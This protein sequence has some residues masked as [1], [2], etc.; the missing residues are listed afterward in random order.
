M[1]KQLNLLH[2]QD[3]FV[4]LKLNFHFHKNWPRAFDT[5]VSIDILTHKLV[6][7]YCLYGNYHTVVNKGRL[8]FSLEFDFC[9]TIESSSHDD[10]LLTRNDDSLVGPRRVREF[11]RDESATASN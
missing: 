4:T 6:D 2:L 10:A 11:W 9:R 1:P 7:E 8:I 3:S 5:F